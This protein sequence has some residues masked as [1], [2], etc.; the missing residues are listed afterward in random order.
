VQHGFIGAERTAGCPFGFFVPDYRTAGM[1]VEYPLCLIVGKRV[2]E[3]VGVLW[4]CTGFV[5]VF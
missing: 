3:T 4:T 1:T 5:P 2:W